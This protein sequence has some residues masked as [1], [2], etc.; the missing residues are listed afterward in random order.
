[1]AKGKL[2]VISGPSGAG[3]GTICKEVLDSERDLK[4]SVSMT[5]RSPREGEVNS[6]HY[7]FVDHDFFRN[8]IAEDGFLE[9]AQVFGNYYGTPKKQVNEWLEQGIDVILEIDVQGALQV[10]EAYPDGVLIFI[11]PPSLE[12][13]KRRITARGSETEET[14]KIRLGEAL[15]EIS[16]IG[17][18]DYRIINED[19]QTA[20]E[21]VVAVIAAERCRVDEG[22][23]QRI[24][25]RYEEGL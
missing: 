25:K 24:I 8:L 17:K 12:E 3:K 18:Y 4:M 14:M 1:M 7:H 9:Y 19:L 6:V 15:H 2:F 10:K 23:S 20:V 13:L 5:T 11:L 22:E 16:T 21:R